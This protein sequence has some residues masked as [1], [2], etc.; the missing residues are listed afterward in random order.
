ME[1][2]SVVIIGAGPAGLTAAYVLSKAGV[3]SIVL[4]K[5]QIVGGLARTVNYKGYYF[6]TGGHR[7]FTK[8]E[9]VEHIWKEVL[10]QELLRRNR[11][12]RIYYN[13]K[14]FYYPLRPLNAL[15][16]LGVWN[17][18]RIFFSY[19]AS[20]LFPSKQE[21]TFEQW[22]SN[23]FGKRLFKTFFKAYTEKVWGIS[24]DEISA[25]W[26]GQRVKGLSLM[27]ALRNAILKNN[28]GRSDKS[29]VIKTL[30]DEF[31]YPKLGP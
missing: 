5:D 16:G 9:S 4:E 21:K 28:N 14:F 8:A 6:D 7:F 29:N 30:I 2:R 15:L 10:G 12:S 26:A 17:S 3:R 27:T 18:L 23:R 25:E 20:Q 19:V 31:D 24:C 13:K 22:V 11:L 1:H